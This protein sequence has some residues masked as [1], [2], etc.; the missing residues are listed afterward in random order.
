MSTWYA[1]DAIV[2]GRRADLTADASRTRLRRS[3]GR[4]SRRHRHTD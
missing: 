1:T 4:R 2:K 3:V